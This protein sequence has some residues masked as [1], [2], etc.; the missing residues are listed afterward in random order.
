MVA[1]STREELVAALREAKPGDEIRLASGTYAG[2]LAHTGLR[3][4]ADNPI[5]LAAA[6]PQ[7]RPVIEGGGSGLHLSSPEHV[8]VRGLVFAGATGNGLNIDDGSNADAPARHIVLRDVVVRE[9]GPKGNTDGIK[10][11]GVD[12]FVVAGCRVERWGEGGSG[13]DMV[14]CH[15]GVIEQSHFLG[16]GGQQANALQTKGGSSDV[17]IRRCR[18]ENPGGRGV[19]VGGSTGLPYFRPFDAAH[20]AHNIT[21]EDCEFLGGECAIAFVGVDGATVHHNTIYRPRHWAIRILQENTGDQ[22]VPSRNG[23]F[24]FN[25]VAFRSDEVRQV[26]NIGGGTDPNSFTFE[27]NAWCCLDRPESTQRLVQLPVAERN[28]VYGDTPEFA[29]PEAGDMSIQ[30]R[31]ADDAG[32]REATAAN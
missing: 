2:G 3:G 27:G 13:I 10:F 30:N 29:D 9:V 8:E 7:H 11:S 28:G 4:T 26:L 32:A 16:R 21:V 15:R 14:G 17:M 25:V 20:E 24:A 23:V 1:V 22:F 19:N 18:I 31:D 12:D 6:D 5:V